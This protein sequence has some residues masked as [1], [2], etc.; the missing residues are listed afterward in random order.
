VIIGKCLGASVFNVTALCLTGGALALTSHIGIPAGSIPLLAASAVLVAA[1]G[2]AAGFAL[3]TMFTLTRHGVQV[4]AALNYPIMILGGMLIPAHLLPAPLALA[5][6]LISLSWA[7]QVLTPIAD[8]NSPP[9]A[10]VISLVL[11][12]AG[13]YAV[14]RL[15]FS[16]IVRRARVK[17]T[18]DLE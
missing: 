8:G 5:A 16:R 2:I 15:L 17:G 14:G 9:I 18:L 12:T 1:S 7:Y 13:Y 6:K 3:C 10:A 4:T 11:I